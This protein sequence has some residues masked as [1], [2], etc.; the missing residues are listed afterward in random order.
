[1]CASEHERVRVC[2]RM[3]K[4]VCVREREKGGEER[5][6]E[7]SETCFRWKIIFFIDIK[8]MTRVTILGKLSFFFEVL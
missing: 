6:V 3:R 7:K 4:R 2:V 5:S 1:M 8:M